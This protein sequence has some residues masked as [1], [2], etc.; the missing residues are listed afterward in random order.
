MTLLLDPYP[1]DAY[2]SFSAERWDSYREAAGKM[3][4]L[5]KANIV[6]RP[7][8]PASGGEGGKLR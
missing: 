1:A 8:S 2:V 7:L 3:P 4:L 5:D 6:T